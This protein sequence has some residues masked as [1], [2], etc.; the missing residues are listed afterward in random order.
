[1]PPYEFSSSGQIGDGLVRA[2]D[3]AASNWCISSLI[4]SGPEWK[5]LVEVED[6]PRSVLGLWDREGGVA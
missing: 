3:A 1:M 2:R 5:T 6:R 4:M